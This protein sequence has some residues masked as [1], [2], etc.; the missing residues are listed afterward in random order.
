[1][2]LKERDI[3]KAESEEV[4]P[5]KI[6]RKI[7]SQADFPAEPSVPHLGPGWGAHGRVFP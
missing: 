1:M 3:G 4:V 7:I 2:Y 5:A 6:E